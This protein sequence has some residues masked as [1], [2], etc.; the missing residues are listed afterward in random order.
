MAHAQSAASGSQAP[1]TPPEKPKVRGRDQVLRDIAKN[2]S[3]EVVQDVRGVMYAYEVD[4]YRLVL[5]VGKR[6][7]MDTAYDIMSEGVSE[8]RARWAD[9]AIPDFKA[10]GT[11]VEQGLAFYRKYLGATDDEFKVM[12]LTKDKVTFKRKDYVNAIFHACDTLGL[13]PVTVNNKVYAPATTLMLA[14]V[15][16]GLKHSF[17]KYDGDGW[18]EEAIEY[19]PGAQPRSDAAQVGANAAQAQKDVPGPQPVMLY[20]FYAGTDGLSHVEKIELKDFDVHNAISLMAGNGIPTIHRDKPDPPA[21]DISKLPFHPAARRQYIFNLQGR[22]QIEFSGGEKITL[23]PGDIELAEDV[24]P[25]KG[26]RNV[27]LGPEDRISAW[28]PITDQTAVIGPSSK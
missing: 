13:D 27:I 12:E 18:Y 17:L 25:A 19:I 4:M 24:A 3:D 20:R 21:T 6:Y 26:H 8:T 28:F 14:R 15:N 22:V 16:P 7:G 10:S 9:Q 1:G 23:N 11:E 2:N 5:R